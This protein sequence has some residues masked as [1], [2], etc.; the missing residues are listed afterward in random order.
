MAEDYI[1]KLDLSEKYVELTK[2]LYKEH[3]AKRPEEESEL[4]LEDF[5]YLIFEF[6]LLNIEIKTKL[7]RLIDLKK[8]FKMDYSKEEFILNYL[9]GHIEETEELILD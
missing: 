5:T 7:E 3:L 4:S 8:Y 1:K 6:G 9:D 2:V